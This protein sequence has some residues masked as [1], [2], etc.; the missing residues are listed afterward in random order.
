[1]QEGKIGSGAYG[2]RAA[3]RGYAAPRAKDR[4]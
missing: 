2:A 4:R 1:M 3:A